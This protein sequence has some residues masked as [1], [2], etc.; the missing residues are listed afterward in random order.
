MHSMFGRLHGE[1]ITATPVLTYRAQPII[2]ASNRCD[3]EEH[4]R[5][6]Q[7]TYT[8]HVRFY[9]AMPTDMPCSLAVVNISQTRQQ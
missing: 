6:M 9:V 1:H 7:F 3:D 5:E 2:Q 4:A 8:T